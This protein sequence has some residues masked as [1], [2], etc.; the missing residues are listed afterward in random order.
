MLTGVSLSLTSDFLYVVRDALCGIPLANA[1]SC[2]NSP[3]EKDCYCES[4][5]SETEALEKP[6][7][8]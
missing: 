1:P 4:G 2:S 3:N 7:L 5:P 8:H 6:N